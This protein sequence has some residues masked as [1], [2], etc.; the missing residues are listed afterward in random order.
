MPLAVNINNK[1]EIIGLLANLIFIIA[2]IVSLKHIISIKD[3]DSYSV[4]S[5]DLKIFANILTIIYGYGVN[6]NIPIIFG[7]IFAL[8]Y[9]L[10]LFM[11][12]V[13]QRNKS[14]NESVY[15]YYNCLYESLKKK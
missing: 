10:L 13:L 7:F 1:F 11:K 3:V 9:T 14:F 15:S 5:I 12:I 8:Y 4:L 2:I 6:Q